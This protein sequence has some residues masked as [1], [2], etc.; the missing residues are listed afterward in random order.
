[1]AGVFEQLFRRGSVLTDQDRQTAHLIIGAPGAGKSRF[2]ETLILQ[3]IEAGRG[4][5]LIDVHGQLFIRVMAWLATRPEYWQRLVIIDP[6]TPDFVVRIN[7]LAAISGLPSNRISEFFKSMFIQLMGIEPDQTPRMTWTMTNVFQALTALGLTLVDLPDFLLS[8]GFR[9]L[10]LARLPREL[11]NVRFFF[12]YEYPKTY[13]GALIYS[14]PLLSRLGPFLFDTD[15]RLMLAG[16]ESLDFRRVMDDGLILLANLPK[17][18]LTPTTSSLLGAFIVSRFQQAAISRANVYD[19]D[20]IRSHYLYLD[21]FQSYTT[22]NISDILDEARKYRLVLTMAHQYLSQL[23]P[24][25][26]SA[27]LN[28]SGVVSCMRLGYED[29]KILAPIIFPR[30]D[31]FSHTEQKYRTIGSGSA[32]GVVIEEDRQAFKWDGLAEVLTNQATRHLWSRRKGPFDPIEVQTHDT[33]DIRW[34]GELLGRI[35]KMRRVAGEHFGV[36]RE[37]A[38]AELFAQDEQRQAL[39]RENKPRGKRGRKSSTEKA[40]KVEKV[41]KPKAAKQ[42]PI[43][44]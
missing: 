26:Q 29:A 40:E 24:R 25:I 18:L 43:S 39:R 35:E 13:G 5:S 38:L 15:S 14:R 20:S 6:T 42:A 21:E 30:S 1:M 41:E 36:Q 2:K 34:T 28:T 17:G 27:V 32:K 8:K 19:D 33:P 4:V 22:E 31:F 12:D 3:D 7:P 9:D 10:H 44:P 11:S 23:D 16:R 37:S